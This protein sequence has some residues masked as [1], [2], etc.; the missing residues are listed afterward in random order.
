MEHPHP[1]AG[2]GIART[3]GNPIKL[4]ETP[5]DYRRPPPMRGQHSRE[6]LKDLLGLDDAEVDRL[7]DDGA[8][9][10]GDPVAPRQG[11]SR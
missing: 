8:L 2:D 9:D 7:A 4:S 1:L 5:V 11:E 3:I 10:L 6:V